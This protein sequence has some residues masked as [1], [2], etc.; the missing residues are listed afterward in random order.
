LDRKPTTPK[1]IP[2]P[3]P[4][5]PR[6]RP[7]DSS[8]SSEPIDSTATTTTT[9]P[10]PLLVDLDSSKELPI[11]EFKAEIMKNIT[12]SD[13]CV[14]IGETGSGKTTELPGMILEVLGEDGK[15][16]ITQPRKIA[17]TSVAKRVASVR[18]QKVGKEIGY[19]IRHDSET[20]ATTRA[21]F[22]T[23]GI[24]IEK[25]KHDALIMDLDAVMIDEAH[26][27]G[28]NTDLLMGLCK[29]AQR[30]RAEQGL[31][32]LKL[33]I[34]S[35]TL[36]K[37][38][39]ENYFNTSP[40]TE[41]PGRLYDV[42]M[43]YEQEGSSIRDYP[44]AAAKKVSSII[45]NGEKGNILIFMPGAREI[46]LTAEAI[47]ELGVA[48]VEI[49]QVHGAMTNEAQQ[50]INEKTSSQRIIIAT[51]I[52]ET[53]LTID[54][55]KHVIDS[56]QIKQIHFDKDSGIES[57]RTVKH[58]KAGCTQRAGRAGRTSE[59]TC[60]RL[61]SKSDFESRE[62]FTSPEIT[63]TC[64]EHVI[65]QAKMI[66][67]EDLSRFDLID[68]PDAVSV[69]QGEK[70]LYELGALDTG[71]EL[72]NLG[73]KMAKLPLE[74]R[75]ARMLI[76]ADRYGCTKEVAIISALLSSGN[77]FIRP[78][79]EAYEADRAHEK[80]KNSNSDF[81]NLLNAWYKFEE[82]G[83]SKEW[84][85]EN[86]LSVKTLFSARQVIKQ[87][88]SAI[89]QGNMKVSSSESS[90]QDFDVD[91]ISKSILSGIIDN[92]TY[93]SERTRYAHRRISD[94]AEAFIFPGSSCFKLPASR[95][96]PFFACKEIVAT[97]KTYMRTNM[98]VYV[99]WLVD[100]APHLISDYS[101]DEPYEQG[102]GVYQR[103][104][105]VMHGT[106]FNLVAELS[107][108]ARKSF[109]E[110]QSEQVKK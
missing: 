108:S 19:Q 78:K 70:V 50:K 51:N 58:S 11:V 55:V 16:A 68:P 32:P 63:R 75:L 37:E 91:R 48:G 89:K 77:L 73:E 23:E 41:V 100:S 49:L 10:A 14:V 40:S 33:I 1:K 72:T 62:E 71:G 105:F 43:L 81:I 46:E 35:A 85:R 95:S 7:L 22:M 69:R 92:L 20:S 2:P 6:P 94:G 26:E 57:L 97:T 4:G 79:E 74:P 88:H 27:R 96:V 82:S 15:L 47:Q 28:V 67:I 52:A 90:S 25:F 76:E 17:A 18:G 5:L 109:K 101:F 29:K 99:D 39:I 59:G 12:E 53:S 103:V 21:T 65:L 60:H 54:G 34:A 107:P 31:K 44:E 24:L 45:S 93:P 8:E 42:E 80:I 9:A 38:K 13:A 110:L 64:L 36:E 106:R 98:P 56:G 61:Y 87:L 3:P 104:S 66:G 86:Y 84:A 30:E 83:L 102:E